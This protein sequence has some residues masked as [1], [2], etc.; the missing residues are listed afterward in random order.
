MYISLVFISFICAI[1]HHMLTSH[2]FPQ[3]TLH[4]VLDAVEWDNLI[5]LCDVQTRECPADDSLAVHPA[6]Y[7]SLDLSNHSLVVQM[8]ETYASPAQLNW[9]VFCA[10]CEILLEEVNA[11]E[12]THDFQ[13]Y[14]TYRYEW[15]LAPSFASNHIEGSLGTIMHLLILDHHNTLYT[16]MFGT[17]RYLQEVKYTKQNQ[18]L[19][20]TD[21]FPNLLNG[22]NS[23]SLTFTVVPWPP[24]IIKY[25]SSA[26][27][28]Y[29][30][31]LMNIIADSMNFTYHVTEPNDQKYGS[32]ENGRW[33]GM[34]GQL[35]DKEA[36]VAASLTQTSDR[37]Q[38]V[39]QIKTAVLVGYEVVMYHKPE[40]RAMSIDA[41]RRPF[42]LEVW[43]ACLGALVTTMVVFHVAQSLLTSQKNSYTNC[44]Y[45][46]YILHSTFNEG[47][48]W[49]P[50]HVSSRIIYSFYTLGWLVLIARYTAYLVS[51][52][53]VKKEVIPFRTMLEFSQSHYKLGVLGG[54][55]YYN[56]LFHSNLTPGDHYFPL[57]SKI[58][59]DMMKDPQVTSSDG[60][61][62]VSRIMTD[63]TYAFF[64]TSASFESLAAVSCKISALEEKGNRSPE[65]FDLQKNSAYARKFNYVLTKIQEEKLDLHLRKQFLPQPAQCPKSYKNVSLEN[66]HG[67]LY[68]LFGGLCIA[69]VV[70]VIEIVSH[71]QLF[72]ELV[73]LLTYIVNIK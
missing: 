60:N 20:R 21:L 40:P 42:S 11:F 56:L 37:G 30:I 41:L 66:I 9:L 63:E 68:I 24:Y 5:L 16:A 6:S 43:L 17:K 1:G 8:F 49:S 45:V 46:G 50:G 57:K 59:Q 13:G 28:G 32:V 31:H 18:Q 39:T 36:D 71:S 23:I 19:R 51:V 70:L 54:T 29:Y 62:H 67:V 33:T 69:L 73:Q 72:S 3:P 61:L 14:L 35:V 22:L 10:H 26:Y 12:N 55:S 44:S 27:S 25:N 58:Q 38:V 34:I 47:T 65:G 48:T 4:D 64:E 7:I 53:S 2:S 52:L 15:I